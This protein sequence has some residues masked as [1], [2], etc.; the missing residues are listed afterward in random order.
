MSSQHQTPIRDLRHA[1]F[2][3]LDLDLNHGL[4]QSN[5]W[6]KFT[7]VGTIISWTKDGLRRTAQWSPVAGLHVFTDGLHRG[8]FRVICPF[9]EARKIVQ[10]MMEI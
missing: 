4:I 9:E 5:G 6:A 10:E 2:E 3:R 1:G 7:S 8:C